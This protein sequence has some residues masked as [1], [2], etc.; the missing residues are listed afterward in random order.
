MKHQPVC[1]TSIIM[2]KATKLQLNPST[3]K[4]KSRHHSYLQFLWLHCHNNNKCHSWTRCRIQ[5]LKII[6]LFTF[7]NISI[8]TRSVE[9]KLHHSLICQSNLLPLPTP[10][11]NKWTKTTKCQSNSH[12]IRNNGSH[13]EL[14]R[15]QYLTGR[16][17]PKIIRCNRFNR[18]RKRRK[19]EL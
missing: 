7:I 16:K 5:W 11:P 8:H 6:E 12:H 18:K 13:K 14:Q 2:I 17:N 4:R 15:R 19:H 10:W 1:K 3:H 9:W